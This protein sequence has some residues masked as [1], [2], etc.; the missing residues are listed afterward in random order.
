MNLHHKDPPSL[1]KRQAE[2]AFSNLGTFD[3]AL[4][5]DGSHL[6]PGSSGAACIAYAVDGHPCK[7][8]RLLDGRLDPE[9]TVATRPPGLIT[10]ASRAEYTALELPPKIIAHGFHKYHD[11][12][13]FI[14]S[15]SQ[16]S[17]RALA[18]GPIHSFSYSGIDWTAL[19]HQYLDLA[20]ESHCDIHI[21]Y[22]PAHVGIIG[23]ELV[24]TVA[25]HYASSYPFLLQQNQPIALSSLHTFLHQFLLA[26]WIIAVTP[27]RSARY[28]I[29][30]T[31]HSN[32][33][34]HHPIP[35]ALQCL[36]SRWRVGE[37]ES[38]GKYPR[39]L[40]WIDSPIC[41]LCGHPEETTLHLL[42][43]CAGTSFY[44]A[45]HGISYLTLVF[46]TP[47]NILRI[48]QFDAW[49]RRILPCPQR[50]NDQTLQAI[51][52][53]ALN[54]RKASVSPTTA[55]DCPA[56][57]RRKLVIPHSGILHSD[58]K[59]RNNTDRRFKKEKRRKVVSSKKVAQNHKRAFT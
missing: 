37:V 22:T 40:R 27:S 56:P 14:G 59:R 41:R 43:D 42:I 1:R 32:L 48:A 35:R 17:L 46:E 8:R 53:E 54:K 31:H 30:G 5:T 50:P 24:D 58:S 15:D 28:N 49:L 57:K 13:I 52:S 18:L 4:W 9:I 55:T 21:Q 47:S 2:E 10:S 19:W 44:R 3:F 7:R 16:A 51:T 26:R 12:R 29:L 25:K 20:R 36:Y 23:N 6:H 33:K 34:L 45:I 11:K 38:V 39:R